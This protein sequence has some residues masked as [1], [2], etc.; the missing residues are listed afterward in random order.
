MSETV[1]GYCLKVFKI[2]ELLSS[3]QGTVPQ[4]MEVE[5]VKEGEVSGGDLNND[6]NNENNEN[7]DE[8]D[9]DDNQY[10]DSALP[11]AHNLP[12]DYQLYNLV[13]ACGPTG[14]YKKVRQKAHTVYTVYIQD[15]TLSIQ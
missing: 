4:P 3:T 6:E 11:I 7:D 12:L 1:T 13:D 2:K 9:D 10:E 8:E 14:I 5:G 15:N